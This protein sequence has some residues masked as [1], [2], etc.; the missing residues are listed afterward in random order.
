MRVRNQSSPP[1]PLLG[2]VIL[3]FRIERKLAEGGMGA[4]Y[5]ARHEELAHTLR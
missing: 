4:V 5:L 3:S 2:K 1:D